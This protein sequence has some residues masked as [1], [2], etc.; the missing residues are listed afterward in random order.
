VAA[1]DNGTVLGGRHLA[2]PVM[3]FNADPVAADNLRQPFVTQLQG[4]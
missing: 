2:V 1:G 3:L 4:Q